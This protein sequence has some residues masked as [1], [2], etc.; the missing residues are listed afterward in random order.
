MKEPFAVAAPVLEVVSVTVIV[1]PGVPVEGAEITA[2]RSAPATLNE[3]EEVQLLL[4][5]DSSTE[6]PSSAQAKM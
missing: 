2:E 6:P 5:T 4:S 3:A 1:E